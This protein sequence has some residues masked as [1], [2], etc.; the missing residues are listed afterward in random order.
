MFICKCG[1]TCFVSSSGKISQ[2]IKYSMISLATTNGEIKIYDPTAKDISGTFEINKR[3]VKIYQCVGCGRDYTDKQIITAL[4]SESAKPSSVAET[5]T[6]IETVAKLY[7]QWIA[8]AGIPKVTLHEYLEHYGINTKS[9]AATSREFIVSVIP[10]QEPAGV[11]TFAN[12]EDI[13][14]KTGTRY[15]LP[16]KDD[17]KLETVS[18]TKTPPPSEVKPKVLLQVTLPNGETRVCQPLEPIIIDVTIEEAKARVMRKVVD[19]L[20]YGDVPLML[21]LEDGEPL[22]LGS[23][24]KQ[25]ASYK[26]ILRYP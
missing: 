4:V 7:N 18:S 23:L 3:F 24:L 14:N 8:D 9:V 2:Q 1:C 22:V 6:D 26:P 13:L 12:N 20:S 19:F 25:Q 10:E 21:T 11:W 15:Y 5:I 17:L 16:S